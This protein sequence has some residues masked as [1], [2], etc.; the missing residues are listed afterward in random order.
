MAAG[1]SLDR[2]KYDAFAQAFNQE[3]RQRLREED[4]Q[5]V[6]LT[7]GELQEE[8]IALG[9]AEALRS[10]GPWGQAFPEPLFD[11]TFELVSRRIVSERH[12]KMVLRLPDSRRIA[13]AIAFN[14]VDED[15]PNEVTR[16]L[17][18]YRLDVN[19]YQGRRNVQLVVEHVEPLDGRS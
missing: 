1:L 16:V 10:A 12:L 15:W 6:L 17:L 7:D 13:D 9:P 14:T 11:G 3:V 8:E 18:A 19:E 4:L 2:H 5:G